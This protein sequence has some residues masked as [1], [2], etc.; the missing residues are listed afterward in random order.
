MARNHQSNQNE[1]RYRA[2]RLKAEA[3]LEVLVGDAGVPA[4]V[5]AS[6]ART[7]LELVGAIGARAKGNTDQELSDDGLEP[8]SMSL[9]D[10][11]RAITLLGQH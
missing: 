5:R 3:A 2:L 4:N 9:A 10:I 11:D 6:A 7:L 8:E 1:G